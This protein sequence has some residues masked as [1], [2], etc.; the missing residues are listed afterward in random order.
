MLVFVAE[1]EFSEISSKSG[2]LYNRKEFLM[3]KL[4]IC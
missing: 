2:I 4:R 3:S 1:E